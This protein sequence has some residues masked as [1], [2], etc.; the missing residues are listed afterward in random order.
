MTTD[1]GALQ[2]AIEGDVVLPG[3]ADYESVRKP[4]MARFEHVRPSAVVRCATPADVAATLAVARGLSLPTAIRSGGHSVAGRSSTDGIVLD[5]TP[6]RSV[7]VAE[8]VAT[9]GAGV[10]LGDLYDELAEHGLTIP[11]G[12]GSS[13]GIA[14]LTLGGGL[15]ILGRKHGLTCDH[16]LRAQVVL[17]DGRV[18]ECD[19]HHDGELFWALRGAG[20]GHFGVVTSLMFRTLPA[21]ATTVFHLVWPPA[22][23]AAVVEAW[24]AYA[25]DAPEEL[26]ATLRLTANRDGGRLPPGRVEVVGSL[27]DGEADAAELLSDFVGRVGTDPVAA[28]R[29]HLPHR[30]A[31]QYLEGLGSVEDRREPSDPE[32]PP[33]PAHL[34][35]KSEFLRRPL[36]SE[37]IG[38]LVEHLSQE[39][40]PGQSREVDFLPWGGAYNRVPTDATAFA[41]RGE[42]FLVQHLVQVGADAAPAERAAA[43][44]W[45]ARSWTLVHPWGSGGVYPNFP[46]PDLRDWAHAY[47]GTNYDRLRRVKAAYDPDGFFRFHQSLP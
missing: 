27:L 10:R 18:V 35:T 21:P 26:D 40:A 15:G 22:A 28:S 31:K 42:R 17:A 3:S 24:Q 8:E 14:G 47:Y 32:Q 33:H 30:A 19:E 16:L 36:P 39:L 37:T 13:V 5:V 29:R 25:P 45:M 9:V 23:A 44:D 7:A 38:T 1:W 20:G 34:Y 6:M 41:H 11:A 43:R 2:R 4:V 12:C 46:D